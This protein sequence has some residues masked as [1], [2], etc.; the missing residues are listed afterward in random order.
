MD[1]LA[2]APRMAT[3]SESLSPSPCS[4]GGQKSCARAK[5]SSKPIG[6][7]PHMEAL[8]HGPLPQATSTPITGPTKTPG[9]CVDLVQQSHT[10]APCIPFPQSAPSPLIAFENTTIDQAPDEEG[11]VFGADEAD[12][13]YM[14]LQPYTVAKL[15]S[16]LK[17]FFKFNKAGRGNCTYV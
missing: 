3:E 11:K 15:R 17:N 7:L 13:F 8:E 9:S 14:F 16:I 12:R 10:H 6:H 5:E 4:T 1:V 2:I